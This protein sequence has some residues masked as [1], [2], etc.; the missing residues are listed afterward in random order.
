MALSAVSALIV[1][2]LTLKT[3]D[4]SASV[5]SGAVDRV[6]KGSMIPWSQPIPAFLDE[7]EATG[8]DGTLDEWNA[9]DDSEG[10]QGKVLVVTETEVLTV[11][12]AVTTMARL[13]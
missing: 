9:Y 11:T 6:N 7:D 8:D 4:W 3:A 13:P 2:S 1:V 12:K 10:I 5:L